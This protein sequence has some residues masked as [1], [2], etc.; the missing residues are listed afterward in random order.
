MSHP[1][2]S[3]R[4]EADFDL[5][6]YNPSAAAGYAFVVLFGIGG[7]V[8]L[9]FVWP[10]RAW[11][12][13][14]LILGCVG[15]AFGY[16]GRAQSHDN[17]R[18]GSPYLLQLMLILASAPLVAATIYMTLGRIIRTLDAEHHAMIRTRW[19]TK[20]YVVIDVGSFVCQMMGSA[21][22]SS[23]DPAGVK[24][25]IKIVV[26]GLGFQLAAFLF[27]IAMAC[28]FHFRLNREPTSISRHP[29]IQWRR[30]MWVLYTT[31][32][33]IFVRSTFRIIEFVEGNEGAIYTHEAFLY[34]FDAF[35]MFLV[36]TILAVFHP[37]RLIKN[38]NQIRKSRANEED[39]ESILITSH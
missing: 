11:F 9:V 37:A 12:F 29:Q 39:V 38:C 13:I 25:G 15:E 36:V 6:P 18:N 33:L 30:D 20:L 22:Q 14:P 10:L 5:Y 31:S 32:I 2:L 35:L 28:R 16:Y 23:G 17:I 1:T 34:V 27:F 4:G 8:H 26:G 19:L 3:T 24:L 21:M 7:V